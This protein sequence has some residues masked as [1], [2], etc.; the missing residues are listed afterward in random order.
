MLIKLIRHE[1]PKDDPMPMPP[2]P[3]NKVSDADIATVT[4]PGSRQAPLC[5]MM[6]P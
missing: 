4:H 5:P 2:P 3:R 1:G 6:F